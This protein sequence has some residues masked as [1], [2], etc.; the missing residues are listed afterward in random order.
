MNWSNLEEPADVS[1]LADVIR[2]SPGIVLRGAETK[3]TLTPHAPEELVVSLRRI[4]GIVAY[5][6]LDFSITALAGT[7]LA[8]IESALA[9]RK[10]RLPFDPPN[11]APVSTLGGS[12]S[13]ALEGP[14]AFQ[15][16]GVRNHLLAVQFCDGI[17]QTLRSGGRVL[18]NS[19]GL[20][21][22]RFLAGSLGRFVA[23]TEITLRTSPL[24]E[25]SATIAWPCTSLERAVALLRNLG[26]S[27]WPFDALDLEVASPENPLNVVLARISGRASA[28]EE[29]AQRI[30]QT[31][32]VPA[33]C[34][35]A[36]ESAARWDQRRHLRW[37]PARHALVKIPITTSSLPA[38][39][40]ACAALE[41]TR[42]YSQGGRLAWVALPAPSLLEST[43]RDLGLK[44]LLIFGPSSFTGSPF[45]GKWP[46]SP[47]M[48]RL[49]LL[50]D[51]KLKFLPW[52]E[53][54][55]L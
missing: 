20:D 34:L 44:G 8:E 32:S 43:L 46:F 21:L 11:L 1:D 54:E 9:E 39:D 33:L 30:V 22:S 24:P 2:S 15:W 38:F 40:A 28:V 18:K 45:L 7:P 31:S 41:A 6:P 25:A 12:V 3:P 51:P 5:H 53:A 26:A 52:P 17:G 19:A 55:T 29:S 42:T 49:K 47:L 50:F 27:P 13:T 36:E 16:G 14:G 10:Q 4:S 37:V 35:S 23:L 48:R